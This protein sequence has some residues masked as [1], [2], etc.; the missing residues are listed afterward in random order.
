MAVTSLWPIK[1]RLDKVI[2]YVRNPE[3]ITEEYYSENAAMH[4]I[5]GVLEYAADDTKTERRAYVTC[6]N[7]GEQTAAR[8]FVDTKKLWRKDDG[9]LC[10][11]GYQSFK[12]GEVNAETA[13]AIGVE[14]AKQLWGERF[15]VVVATHCNTGVYHNHFVINSVSFRDGYKFY[16]SKADYR[17]MRGVSDRLCREHGLSVIEEAKG[18]GKNHA[19]YA[20]EQN[21]K[22]THAQM[23]RGDI[24][25]AIAASLTR[26][27]FFQVMEKMGY[28]ITTHGKSGAPLKH[29]KLTPPDAG[30]N[31]RFDTLGE[32]Y[33]LERIWE[34]IY[35]NTRRT[36]AF[37]ESRPI[38][39]I[40]IQKRTYKMTRKSAKKLT[41]LRALYFK[42][43]VLLGT[44]K[45]HPERIQRPSYLLREDVLKLDRYIAKAKLLIDNK[46]ETVADLQAYRK[47]L[48]KSIAQL[49][50]ER[51]ELR[52]ALKRVE[53]AEDEPD[54][55]NCT[56]QI[57]RVSASIRKVRKEVN[58]CNEIEASSNQ[59]SE[60]L[61]QSIENPNRQTPRY[62]DNLSDPKTSR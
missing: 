1:Y 11:H 24:D 60:T 34:R 3:K 25:R 12:P 33:T 51:K 46:I 7:C 44:V 36:P 4:V 17:Q 19:L 10:Y 41:G 59:V 45:N 13:H 47:G 50:A 29:P 62:Q 5:D 31:Y 40:L 8:D 48:Q 39:G 58:L 57:K 55:W 2:N 53:R 49:A 15:Q 18:K 30:K 16:N 22:P 56:A 14:L 38:K 6:L 37:A 21:S 61:W 28:T 23:I 9:R 26:Q 43:C 42:Y 35:E 52:N 20:A 54:K 32:D 27:E